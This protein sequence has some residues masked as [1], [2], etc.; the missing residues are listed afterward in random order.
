MIDE[1][2]M[3]DRDMLLFRAF[4]PEVLRKRVVHLNETFEQAWAMRIENG[5][6]YREGG[7]GHH[8]RAKGVEALMKRFVKHVPDQV[9]IYNGHDNAR[10]AVAADERDRL[11]TL[12]RKGECKS[13]SRGRNHVQELTHT[14]S[15]LR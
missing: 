11:E 13:E 15:T 8:D 12:A 14:F 9:M 6:I 7:F 2:D 4:R 10:I 3:I 5:K 1:F